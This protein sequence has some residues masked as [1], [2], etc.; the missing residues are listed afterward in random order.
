M[1]SLEA[2]S[3]APPPGPAPLVGLFVGGRS[4]RMGGRP[5][6]LLPTPDGAGPIVLR[7]ARLVASLGWPLVLV[8]EASAYRAV[9][10]GVKA[11]DD[12]PAGVGPLGG[13]GA[14]LAEAGAGPAIAL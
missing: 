10:P 4:T 13:L 8:G 1:S 3:P 2:P 12:A 14:L 9:L 6:G 11:I 5:K 7:S